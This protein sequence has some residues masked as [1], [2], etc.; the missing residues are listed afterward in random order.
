[1]TLAEIARELK[2]SPSTVS[3]VLNGYSKNFGANPEMRARI[4]EMVEKTGYRPNPV[5]RSIRAKKNR[6]IAF[7][8]YSRSLRQ[9]GETVDRALDEAT[10]IL[11]ENGF[12][13][14]YLF[15]PRAR[16]ECYPVPEWKVAGMV[17]PDVIDPAM[18]RL[19]EEHRCP[20]VTLNGVCGEAGSAVMSDEPANIRMVM[21]YLYRLGHRRIAYLNSPPVM[22]RHH[23]GIEREQGYLDFLNARRLPVIDGYG[24]TPLPVA[25]Q[26]ELVRRQGATAIVT[27]QL[28]IAVEV[29]ETAWRRGVKVPR[30]LS[31]VT[32]DDSWHARHTIPPLTC[33]KIAANEMGKETARLIMAKVA[34]PEAYK[35]EMFRFAGEVIERE[36]TAPP[37]KA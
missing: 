23:S 21:E 7:S 8:F 32:F 33:C 24:I 27:F 16:V 25:E 18:L 12:T 34:D 36:S 19:I 10:R 4:L 20:Y 9:N 22:E 31:V 29:L 1:M 35:T 14:H 11:E 13:F 28:E 2:V 3:R 5:F 26:F 37:P 30:E 15:H 17:I 6:Q